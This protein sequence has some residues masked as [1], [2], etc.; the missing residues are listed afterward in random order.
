MYD[1]A[2]ALLSCKITPTTNLNG[3]HKKN[4]SLDGTLA[5]AVYSALHRALLFLNEEEISLDLIDTILTH[6]PEDLHA[7]FGTGKTCTLLGIP[8]II[9]KIKTIH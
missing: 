4:E 6:Y 2:I 9:R 3:F 5:F 7:K 8:L 1:F